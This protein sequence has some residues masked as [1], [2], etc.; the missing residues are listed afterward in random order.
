VVFSWFFHRVSPED[1]M[2]F[3]SLG[4]WRPGQADR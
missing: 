4:W 2:N 3:P 1:E